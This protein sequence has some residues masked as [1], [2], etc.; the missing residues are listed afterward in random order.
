MAFP[1]E[2]SSSSSSQSSEKSKTVSKKKQLGKRVK[3]SEGE[4]AIKARCIVCERNCSKINKMYRGKVV[5]DV[6]MYGLY[7]CAV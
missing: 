6:L 4:K 3:R 1:K 5:S 7:C 2:I